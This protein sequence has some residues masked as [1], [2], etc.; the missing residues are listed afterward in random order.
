MLIDAGANCNLQQNSGYTALMLAARYSS[1]D[2]SEGTVKMLIDASANLNLQQKDGWTALM[3][4]TLYSSTTSSEGTIRML[5]DAGADPGIANS[6]GETALTLA[7]RLG[8][9]RLIDMLRPM[10][11]KLFIHRECIVCTERQPDVWLRPC[12]HIALCTDCFRALTTSVCP[13]CRTEITT[14]ALVKHVE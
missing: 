1:T 9:Q 7:T 3:L 11:D 6:D 2:S 5:I 12:G 8:N 13:V 14:H 10:V 4:A